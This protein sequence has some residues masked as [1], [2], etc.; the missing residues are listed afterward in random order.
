MRIEKNS[1]CIHMQ[2]Y[3]CKTDFCWCCMG[4]LSDHQQ[5]YKICPQLPYSKCVNVMV[6]LVVV[7]LMPI[8]LLIVPILYSFMV[9]FYYAPTWILRRLK[10]KKRI[11]SPCVRW[12]LA[13]V[14]SFLVLLPL[15]I[16]LSAVVALLLVVLGTLPAWFLCFSYLWRLTTNEFT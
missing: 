3:R 15:S 5:W 13:L 6:T 16:V 4:K 9:G 8:I 10:R 14:I 7:I 1:G 11:N 12:T 2:C